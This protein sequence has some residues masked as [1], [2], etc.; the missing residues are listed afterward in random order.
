MNRENHYREMAEEF[1]QQPFHIMARMA[2]YRMAPFQMAAYYD[3]NYVVIFIIAFGSSLVILQIIAWL[4]TYAKE[5]LLLCLP[6]H[7][8][9]ES[10][11][12]MGL[13]LIHIVAL[14]LVV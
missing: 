7:P 8:L 11:F 12:P 5:V 13:T 4:L 1:E 10:E 6:A 3:M 2:P 14:L 9:I